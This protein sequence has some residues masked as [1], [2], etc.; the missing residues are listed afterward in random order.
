MSD[1]VPQGYNNPPNGEPLRPEEWSAGYEAGIADQA[2]K[3]RVLREALRPFAEVDLRTQGVH[4]KF[5]EHV[6]RARAALE[7]TK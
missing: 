3:I 1:D 5:A 2:E 4:H 6:L 7:A